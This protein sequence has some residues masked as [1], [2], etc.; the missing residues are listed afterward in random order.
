MH[1]GWEG[2]L[3]WWVRLEGR[4]YTPESNCTVTGM[5]SVQLPQKAVIVLID[6]LVYRPSAPRI[7]TLFKPEQGT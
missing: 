2:P 1:G 4:W 7:V 5:L 6:G 3:S